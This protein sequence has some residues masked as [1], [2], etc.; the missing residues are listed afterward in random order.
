M[1]KYNEP[2]TGDFVSSYT[3]NEKYIAQW[4]YCREVV[5]RRNCQKNCQKCVFE[6]CESVANYNQFEKFY[7]KKLK[8]VKK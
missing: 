2:D 1:P 7:N 4:D 3:G 8:G 6:I 5:T